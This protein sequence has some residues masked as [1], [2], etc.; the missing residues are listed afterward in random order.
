MSRF[1]TFYLLIPARENAWRQW[2]ECYDSSVAHDLEPR[3]SCRINS[4]PPRTAKMR[5][6]NQ[7][8]NEEKRIKL[9]QEISALESN[10]LED[11]PSLR[12]LR[13][14]KSRHNTLV[15]PSSGLFRYQS[16]CL[17]PEMWIHVL[18]KA[19]E[20]DCAD[21][22]PLTLVC[23]RWS[24]IILSTPRLW[25]SIYIRADLDALEVA[26][27]AL[28][29]SKGL[30][31]C[32]TVDVTTAPIVWKTFLE[33]EITRVQ[34]LNLKVPL[35]Y[36]PSPNREAN[37]RLDSWIGRLFRDMRS[38]SSLESLTID[39]CGKHFTLS[40]ALRFL[41]APNITYLTPSL[42]PEPVSELSRF[43]RLQSLRV[44][45]S[46]KT[47]IS[48]LIT[49]TD[50][51]ELVL[52]GSALEEQGMPPESHTESCKSIAPLESLRSYQEPWIYILPLLFSVRSSIRVLE[53]DIMWGHVFKLLAAVH[54]APCL[55][56][57]HI[58]VTINSK[59]E[60]KAIGWKAPILSQ[61]QDFRL[62]VTQDYLQ[63]TRS[64]AKLNR[65]LLGALDGSLT[66]IRTLDLNGDTFASDLVRFLKSM[67][68][69]NILTIEGS[70]QIDQA[71]TISCPSLKTLM[72]GTE[73]VLRYVS[74]PNLISL[75]I[76]NRYTSGELT[77]GEPYPEIDRS[78]VTS[79]QTLHLGPKLAEIIDWTDTPFTQLVTLRWLNRGG[80]YCYPRYP[81]PSLTKIIFDE[82]YG[83]VGATYFCQLLLRY[84]RT[85]PRLETIAVHGYP[86]WDALLYMLL[87]RNVY[88]HQDN[89]SRI[90]SIEIPGYPAPYILAP[91]SA[92]LQG[93]IPLEMPSL[94]DLSFLDVP[95]MWVI[96]IFIHL[97][98]AK[99][100][101][102]LR[103]TSSKISGT[104][105]L[106]CL[107]GLT[108]LFLTTSGTGST[109]G[110][111][112][113]VEIDSKE[114]EYP[115]SG[116]YDERPGFLTRSDPLESE[117]D[118]EFFAATDGSGRV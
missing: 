37:E 74:M 9:L 88:R 46:L 29:L 33:I 103:L 42:S 1:N 101:D 89:I 112:E 31:L 109:A 25:T 11:L 72:T 17:P 100:W 15:E 118:D 40:S 78:F 79:V 18:L 35:G 21:I 13:D 50:L 94:K 90:T 105:K 22:L 44:N 14:L 71:R 6:T 12:T 66:N 113:G 52:T 63:V 19:A 43:N 65:A 34:H 59:D 99:G 93:K 16:Q 27:L 54:E 47:V 91:L 3:H 24:S 62:R 114:L 81:F 39:R 8:A 61:I 92:L 23:Q 84:P 60:V 30:P 53:L 49:L 96:P 38:L 106:I 110:K 56:K 87:R 20:D 67:Q 98:P 102:T 95:W 10:E 115:L 48:E 41:N 70:V 86:E 111:K 97:V 104:G 116:T 76:W 58:N 2:L 45:S 83:S 80:W 77:T 82:K 68:H 55:H 57:L 117:T 4:E 69:L 75:T 7:D 26:H 51:K 28:F 64:G 36:F 108:R 73:Q 5:S 107:S 85:C 32:M